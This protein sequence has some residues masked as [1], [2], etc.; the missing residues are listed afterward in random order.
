MSQHGFEIKLI[1]FSNIDIADLKNYPSTQHKYIPRE[2]NQ[3]LK[4]LQ[5]IKYL[6]P[7]IC[8]NRGLGPLAMANFDL[9]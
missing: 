9:D 6:G 4:T 5:Y 1:H 8:G 2:L 3:S 7:T